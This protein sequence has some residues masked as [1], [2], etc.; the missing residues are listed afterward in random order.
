MKTQKLARHT[1]PYPEARKGPVVLPEIDQLAMRAAG[2]TAKWWGPIARPWA[3]DPYGE[4]NL[5]R[6][7]KKHWAAKPG[8]A[9]KTGDPT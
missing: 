6:W 1:D 7:F 8:T 3:P 9:P 5:V 2:A 4:T